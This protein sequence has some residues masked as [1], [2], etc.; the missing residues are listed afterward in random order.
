M[1]D[2]TSPSGMGPAVIQH[3]QKQPTPIKG[4]KKDSGKNRME[5]M[6][7]FALEAIAEVF[8]FGAQKY[9][10]WNW[11]NGIEFSRV[12]G[13]LQRHMNA[14]YRGEDADPETGKS[15]LHHAGCCIMMLIELERFHKQ[16]D[17]RPT[18]YKQSN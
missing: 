7:P 5:L 4:H 15:H 1:L 17:D 11:A 9:S 16:C 14:W 8:T 13:A 18:H 3:E 12:Y 6:P 10:G 2:E